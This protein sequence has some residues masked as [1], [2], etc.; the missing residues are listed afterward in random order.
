[1]AGQ[2]LYLRP[3]QQKWLEIFGAFTHGIIVVVLNKSITKT[4]TQ[5]PVKAG[6]CIFKH[7]GVKQH[8]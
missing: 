8:M 2:R 3:I 4:A 5:T 6:T 7:V 1:V